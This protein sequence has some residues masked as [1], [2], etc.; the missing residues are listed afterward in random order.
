[1]GAPEAIHEI[2]K[3]ATIFSGTTLDADPIT[4]K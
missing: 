1:V 2:Y 3:L 4:A